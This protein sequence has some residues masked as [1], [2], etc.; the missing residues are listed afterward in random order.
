MQNYTDATLI[1]V[2]WCKCVCGQAHEWMHV[3]MLW[4][5]ISSTAEDTMV[6]CYVTPNSCW[7]HAY[8]WGARQG[9]WRRSDWGL[10]RWWCRRRC[11]MRRV[12]RSVSHFQTSEFFWLKFLIRFIMHIPA[13]IKVIAVWHSQCQ[14]REPGSTAPS[15]SMCVSVPPPPNTCLECVDLRR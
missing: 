14:S 4:W 1:F 12:C 8:S 10:E 15:S 3:W 7:A 5:F 6:H 2:L 9:L 13:L 11:G